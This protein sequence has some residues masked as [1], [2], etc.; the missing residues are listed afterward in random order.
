M[1]SV[2]YCSLIA[3]TLGK[4]TKIFTFCREKNRA[5]A[6]RRAVTLSNSECK[7]WKLQSSVPMFLETNLK[8]NKLF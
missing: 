7:L 6:A 1:I 2:T 5:S 8:H 3:Q 4:Q